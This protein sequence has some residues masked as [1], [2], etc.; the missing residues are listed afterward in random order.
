MLNMWKTPRGSPQNNDGFWPN[1]LVIWLK[2]FT[3]REEK[4][5]TITKKLNTKVN[6]Q[7]SLKMPCKLSTV[8]VAANYQLKGV[9]E[10]IGTTAGSGH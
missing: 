7:E 5:V 2:R 9:I 6:F 10:H 4:G 8:G 1:I 3:K